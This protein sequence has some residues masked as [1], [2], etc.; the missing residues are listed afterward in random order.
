MEGMDE[1]SLNLESQFVFLCNLGLQIFIN[2]TKA[3]PIARSILDGKNPIQYSDFLGYQK[4]RDILLKSKER[5]DLLLDETDLPYKAAGHYIDCMLDECSIITRMY[6]SKPIS[7]DEL[8]YHIDFH[9]AVDCDEYNKLFLPEV[10]PE[11]RY[12]VIDFQKKMDDRLVLIYA[13][14]LVNL[15]LCI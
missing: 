3:K 14:L 10:P 2:M 6:L 1:T 9:E 11:N 4:I 7:S 13:Q 5:C 8:C 15:E 12:D